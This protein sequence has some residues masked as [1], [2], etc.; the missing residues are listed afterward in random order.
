LTGNGFEQGATVTLGG[1]GVTVSSVAVNSYTSITFS[2][3][4]AGSAKIGDRT[5]TVTNP[6]GASVTCSTCFAVSAAPALTSASPSSL[7]P[8]VKN[9]TVVLSGSGFKPG[10]AVIISGAGVKIVSAQVVSASEIK[11]TLTVAAKATAGARTV[12]V[13]NPDGGTARSKSLSIT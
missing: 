3:S 4:V 9:V 6:D 7:A 12:T 5:I 2:L 8:G 13:T 11:L 10:A 1:T